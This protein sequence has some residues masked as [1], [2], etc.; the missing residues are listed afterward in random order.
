MFYPQCVASVPSVPPADIKHMLR[1]EEEL[2]RQLENLQWQQHELV[3]QI[4]WLQQKRFFMENQAQL[5]ENQFELNSHCFNVPSAQV[6]ERRKS[7]STSHSSL[8]SAKRSSQTMKPATNQT[9]MASS[10]VN[11]QTNHAT[12]ASPPV[13]RSSTTWEA[14]HVSVPS[15]DNQTMTPSAPNQA[16]NR[17]SS[18]WESPAAQLVGTLPAPGINY[19]GGCSL[20]A[21]H[22]SFQAPSQFTFTI[23]ASLQPC[24]TPQPPQLSDEMNEYMNPT[25]A[26]PKQIDMEKILVRTKEELEES[27]WFY[28]DLSWPAANAL[29]ANAKPGTFLVR[30]SQD[31]QTLYSLSVQRREGPTSVRIQFS[32]GQFRLDSCDQKIG[33]LLP[34]FDSVGELIQ[35]YVDKGRSNVD[36]AVLTGLDDGKEQPPIVLEKPLYKSPPSLLHSSRLAV[37]RSMRGNVSRGRSELGSLELPTKLVEYI[38]AYPMTI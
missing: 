31:P 29:L 27:N 25:D 13:K 10:P 22:N 38:K 33:E 34:M 9:T 36:G 17:S 16:V 23:S 11:S 15:P 20:S 21:N 37:N 28:G 1:Q 26:H 18:T 3:R 14:N 6:Y 12:T 24:P 8:N 4:Q 5:Y 2:R 35:H 30:E 32:K 7:A 19:G